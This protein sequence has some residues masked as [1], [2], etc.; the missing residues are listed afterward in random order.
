MSNNS[1]F[2]RI[3]RSTQFARLGPSLAPIGRR[4]LLP[5]WL[6][7]LEHDTVADPR[8]G[9]SYLLGVDL[10]T[11]SR[12]VLYRAPQSL[13]GAIEIV[14]LLVPQDP[15]GQV[16]VHVVEPPPEVRFRLRVQIQTRRHD[17]ATCGV[18]TAIGAISV[19]NAARRALVI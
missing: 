1:S 18:M 2:G 7:I 11:I 4:F 8:T 10:G 15:D 3:R 13:G 16:R 5:A 12:A 6:R 9:G 17:R 19:R 14:A